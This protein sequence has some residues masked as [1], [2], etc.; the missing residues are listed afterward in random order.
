MKKILVIEDHPQM[1][2]NV[3]TILTMEG[4]QAIAAENG[5]LGL[6]AAREHRPDMIICDVMMPEL[7]GLGV[8]AAVRADESIANIP[9]ILLTARGEKLDQ[10]IGMNLGADDYLSKP[11]E[12]SELMAA[13][14]ARL[15]RRRI[16]DD[17]ARPFAPNFSSATPLETALGLTPRQAEVLLWVAQGK[18][19]S[20]IGSILGS[21]ES[22]VKKHLGNMFEKLG[23]ENRASLMVLALEHLSNQ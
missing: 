10:R 21:A 5:R 12:H 7:D 6:A 8:L 1:R 4:Y 3:T 16:Q 20:E 18:S 13:V 14:E 19:N 2:R 23:V 22:T 11:V 17:N 15:I 9:F